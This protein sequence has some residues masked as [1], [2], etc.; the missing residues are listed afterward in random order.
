[1]KYDQVARYHDFG[2]S[3]DDRTYKFQISVVRIIKTV[4]NR[5]LVSITERIVIAN[6][7]TIFEVF[8][9]KLD[10]T[11][12]NVYYDSDETLGRTLCITRI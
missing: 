1:M 10:R 9:A 6:V 3:N 12:R 7:P 4:R 8:Y 5:T 2:R 11:S